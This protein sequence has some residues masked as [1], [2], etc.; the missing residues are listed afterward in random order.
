[1]PMTKPPV[2]SVMPTT[3]LTTRLPGAM[4]F[5]S[6]AVE[7]DMGRDLLVRRKITDAAPEALGVLGADIEAVSREVIAKL[8][9]FFATQ[10]LG[11]VELV[12]AAEP[13]EQSPGGGKFRHVIARSAREADCGIGPRD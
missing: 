4:A 13:P 8:A 10:G 3:A 6:S 12:R 5:V 9:S 2:A 11:N 7:R 1:M